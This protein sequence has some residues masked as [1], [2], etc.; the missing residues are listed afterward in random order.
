MENL[1]IWHYLL[2]IVL[3][4]VAGFVNV[5]SAGGSL[6]TMPLLIF[7][8]LPPS[9]A[10]G[11]NRIGIMIQNI[12]AIYGFHTKG[13]ST[14]KF[15]SW[16]SIT[17]ILGAYL[18]ARLAI[19][20][21]DDLFNKILAVVMAMVML[22]TIFHT[23]KIRRPEEEKTD[24]KSQLISVFMF[25]IVGIY[26]GFIQAGVG[27]LIMLTMSWV[28]KMTL[29]K[30]NSVKVFVILMYNLLAFSVFLLD[31]K[32]NWGLGL[33]LAAGMAIGGWIAA[34]WS[35]KKG[36][37]WIRRVL[38]VAVTVMSIKLWFFS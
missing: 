2:V 26:G 32:V 29:V 34:R 22:F 5:V 11:T 35:V 20:I 30:A 16:L 33:C 7:M 9:T 36:D 14:F 12:V 19:I 10:N 4:T 24:F 27:V 21:P 23:K 3:G 17:A 13:V 18:G 1:T 28:N 15:S 8:G 38:I 31:D 37:V 25:F 6:M